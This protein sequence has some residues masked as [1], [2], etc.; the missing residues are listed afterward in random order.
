MLAALS[1]VTPLM[2]AGMA[3]VSLPVIAHLLNWRTRRRIV[4]PT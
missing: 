3:L 2:L 4:F 1:F